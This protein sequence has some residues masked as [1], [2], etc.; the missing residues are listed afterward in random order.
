MKVAVVILNYNGAEHLRHFLPSVV[1]NTV[2]ADVVVADNGSTDE[3]LQLLESEFASVRIVALDRNYGF[4]EGYNRALAQLG[5]YDCFVLLNSDVMTP[6]GWLEPLVAT[7]VSH[8]SIVAVGPKILSYKEP[9]K[10]EYAGASGGFI[11]YLGYPLCR[12][13]I[14][15]TIE[16]DRGQYDTAREVF[17]ASGAAFCCRADLFHA[18]G[19]FDGDFFAHMEEIDLCWRMQLAGYKIM[20][21]PKSVVYHLGGGTLPNESPNK[22]YLNYRNN[23]A[24]LYKCAPTTQR[25]TV[26][27]LRPIADMLSMA[28]YLLKGQFKLANATLRAYRDFM[29]WHKELSRKR[30]AIRGNAKAE[31]KLIYRGSMVLRYMLGRHTFNDMI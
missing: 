20:S 29:L 21:E 17:W 27:I 11:D 24:M 13:R 2:A 30:K 7:L 14:L 4:A 8:G 3:S 25:L 31:S 9:D 18:M 12:G 15:S 5:E 22:L 28:I 1:Q 26:A 10:F 6:E 23:L 19:G 16:Q